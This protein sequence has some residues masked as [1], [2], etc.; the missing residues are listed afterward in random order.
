MSCSVLLLLITP[1]TAAA[2]S[3]VSRAINA[4]LS[5]GVAFPAPLARETRLAN[6]V[7]LIPRS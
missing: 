7:S 1:A 4:S 6:V 3:A 2:F 5:S